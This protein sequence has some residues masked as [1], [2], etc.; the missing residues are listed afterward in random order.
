M[1][2]PVTKERKKDCK[3]SIGHKATHNNTI[4]MC[5]FKL[6]SPFGVVVKIIHVLTCL[7]LY[8]TDWILTCLHLK[9]TGACWL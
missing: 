3:T 8:K 6:L 4:L 5:A 7:D 1:S 9:Y 2:E